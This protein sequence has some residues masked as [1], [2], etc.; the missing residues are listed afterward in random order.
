MKT[1]AYEYIVTWQKLLASSQIQKCLK[2]S[3]LMHPSYNNGIVI[4]F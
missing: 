4:V 3:D 2:F 1:N